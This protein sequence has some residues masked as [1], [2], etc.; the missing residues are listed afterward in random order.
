MTLAAR[1]HG[2]LELSGLARDLSFLRPSL[3]PLTTLSL[4]VS[5][6]R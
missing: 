4:A 6:G 3:G 5:P 1:G 2:N